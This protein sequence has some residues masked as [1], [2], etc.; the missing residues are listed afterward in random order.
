MVENVF[1]KPPEVSGVS[2]EAGRCGEST[3]ALRVS[4]DAPPANTAPLVT[5]SA[6]NGGVAFLDAGGARAL[7]PLT[8][9]AQARGGGTLTGRWFRIYPNPNHQ[10]SEIKL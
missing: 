2:A 5:A 4:W 9:A 3:C 7:I 8:G 10:Q 1:E 6:A